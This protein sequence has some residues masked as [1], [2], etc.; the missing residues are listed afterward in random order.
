MVKHNKLT[1]PPPRTDTLAPR[2]HAKRYD[3]LDFLKFIAIFLVICRHSTILP[4][5]FLQA[6]SPES[7]VGY[8]IQIFLEGVPIFVMISGFLLLPKKIDIRKY[9]GKI[10]KM[11]LLIVIWCL[12]YSICLR[13]LHGDTLNLRVVILD[14]LNLKSVGPIH[15][16]GFL[17]YLQSLIGIYI[18]LPILGYIFSNNKKIY[19]YLT[20]VII[21]CSAGITT[22][23]LFVN[24]LASLLGMKELP[25][26]IKTFLSAYTPLKGV[27]F[28]SFFLVGGEIYLFRD[29]LKT[30][31]AKKYAYI[32]LITSIVVCITYGIVSAF[33]DPKLY[34][35]Y[36][37][38]DSIFMLIILVSLYTITQDYKKKSFFSKLFCSIGQNSLGIYLLHIFIIQVFGILQIRNFALQI[39]WGIGVLLE[40]IIIL[41]IAYFMTKIL[42]KIPYIRKSITM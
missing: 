8:A 22:I 34:N 5:N 15:Q 18:L 36:F 6:K 1:P 21:L 40:N 12:L 20:I 14:F 3:N 29:C 38:Y 32:T 16:S 30:Q 42:A 17:W 31:K 10:K 26:A 33:I 23:M 9:F 39:P 41:L 24:P 25:T 27:S 37:V 28:L 4:S 13:F 7:F 2:T 11:F 35:N 19:H